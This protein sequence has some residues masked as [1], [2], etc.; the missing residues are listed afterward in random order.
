[1]RKTEKYC[2]DLCGDEF[3]TE[4]ECEAH[5]AKHYTNWGKAD[6]KQIAKDL[7]YISDTAHDYRFGEMVLGYFLS[8]FEALMDEAAKRIEEAEK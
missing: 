7:R 1:M 8:D 5:E 6:N 2:C 3:D 4:E